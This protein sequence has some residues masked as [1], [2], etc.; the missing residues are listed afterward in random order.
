MKKILI[1]L[2]TLLMLLIFSFFKEKPIMQQ[3]TLQKQ[4][5]S[6]INYLTPSID[7]KIPIDYNFKTQKEF[8]F[9]SDII[10]YEQKEETNLLNFS[11]CHSFT[12]KPDALFN[13]FKKQSE[14]NSKEKNNLYQIDC[15]II[16]TSFPLSF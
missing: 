10:T 3:I 14:S 9:S 1:F 2:I 16:Q 15:G 7:L 5:I 4:K 13:K 6:Q 12:E 11:Q 8:S